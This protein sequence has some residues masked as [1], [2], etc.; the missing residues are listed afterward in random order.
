MIRLIASDIDGT[1]LQNGSRELN[2]ELFSLIDRLSEKG[3][4][5]CAASGRQYPNLQRLFE[6]VKDRIAFITENGALVMNGEQE[7]SVC[8]MPREQSLALIEDIQNQPGCE[9]QISGKQQVYI[10]PRNPAYVDHIRNFV[11]NHTVLCEDFSAIEEPFLK[12]SVMMMD[13]VDEESLQ[14]FS[15]KWGDKFN[16]A[17]SGSCWV[18][19]TL[20]NK[21]Q[22]L[23]DLCANLGIPLAETAAFGDN[24]NDIEMLRMAKYAWAMSK[25]DDTIKNAAGRTCAKVEPVLQSILE[26]LDAL[27]ASKQ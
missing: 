17:L 12:V 27:E 11:K 18:D 14:Y 7:V 21:A 13:G 22:G 25:A 5:F 8:A 23:A 3:I 1:L 16:V 20:A 15:R 6:P 10:S 2:P 4:L 9:V 19:F 26:A 24:Y